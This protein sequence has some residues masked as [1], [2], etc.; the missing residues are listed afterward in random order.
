MRSALAQQLGS[1]QSDTRP[2]LETVNRAVGG[3]FGGCAF[4]KLPQ[5]FESF[6]R[7]AESTERGKVSTIPDGNT[8]FQARDFLTDVRVGLGLSGGVVGAGAVAVLGPVFEQGRGTVGRVC[9]QA[10]GDDVDGESPGTKRGPERHVSGAPGW[11]R[12]G[13]QREPRGCRG[14]HGGHVEDEHER[15]GARVG[16]SR[17]D[18]QL[19]GP[20][21]RCGAGARRR[22]RQARGPAEPV[23]DAWNGRRTHA[24][25]PDC[26]RGQRVR[27]GRDR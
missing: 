15:L 10:D 11:I 19:L 16:C 5:C 3:R 27:A 12:H 25:R 23:R 21:R 4:G 17:V 18:S 2:D 26:H 9:A 1:G 8:S 22:G 14:L 6:R 13:G 24:S 7:C 20:A